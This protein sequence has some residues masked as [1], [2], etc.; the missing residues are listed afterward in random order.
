MLRHWSKHK[1]SR[2][3]SLVEFMMILPLIL[4]L[5]MV[6]IEV[7]R[8][9]HAWVGVENAARTGIRYAVT[10][11]WS[12][13]DCIILYGGECSSETQEETARVHSIKN[14]AISGSAAIILDEA[15]T[16]Y[17]PGFFG[18]TVCSK[19]GHL[20]MPTA[21]FESYTCNDDAGVPFEYAG[22]PGEYVIVGVDYNL[23]LISPI[24]STWFP[25][26]HLR[27]QRL[28]KVENYRFS[29][30]PAPPPDVP[31]NTATATKTPV[32]TDTPTIT[33]TP[34]RTA[35][36][37]KTPTPTATPDCSLISV[38][39]SK[40]NADKIQIQV[41]NRGS[42]NFELTNSSMDWTKSLGGQ[43][44]NFFKWASSNYYIGD[45]FSPP[46]ISDPAPPADFF[47]GTSINWVADFN[48]IS[49]LALY[50]GSYTV[51]L[52]FEY[53]CPITVHIA[54]VIATPTVPAP[55]CSEIYA[56]SVRVNG[57]DFEINVRNNNYIGA[58]LVGSNVTWPDNLTPNIFINDLA[59][60][61]NK[62][63]Y[64]DYH[65]SVTT[66]L[67]SNIELTSRSEGW[68]E[69]DFNNIPAAG[70]SGFFQGVLRFN[71]P[72]HGLT[73]TVTADL[74][75]VHTPVPTITTT[76]TPSRTP[77]IT[78]TP[79]PSR[80]P[81]VTRTP[82]PSI[83][84]TNTIT[85]TP[86]RTPTVTRTPSITPTPTST[87][88]PDCNKL[89]VSNV[90]FD[91][92]D[93]QF[94]IS[95]QNAMNIYLTNSVLTWPASQAYP[96]QFFNFF[97]FNTNLYYNTDS[98]S[99][100]V[101]AAAPSL[102]LG[103][104]WKRLWEADFD[105]VAGFLGTYGATLTFRFESGL[106]CSVSASRTMLPTSTPTPTNTSPPPTATN[107]PTITPICS[108][109]PTNTPIPPPSD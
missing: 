100:P 66:A 39:W 29:R 97:R 92:D 22:A 85:P 87:L 8:I 104:G 60:V 16:K 105:N 45:D 37:S 62:W 44:V 89:E 31:T 3:Q 19:P 68:W 93:F 26:L 84:P 73:C 96:P 54:N 51:E 65:T 69:V 82:T 12:E 27:S 1:K 11:E 102:Q 59:F 24:V 57:D 94:D 47:P 2:G 18:V 36:P 9:F 76:P 99:S 42:D 86:S 98:T 61:G 17:N 7:A 91:S 28:A 81:T 101:S 52:V 23:P 48:G 106:T 58:Y 4:T 80:T 15:A 79:T 64:G 10:G 75:V 50:D 103:P 107:T 53:S 14:A 55:D 20:Q 33:L 38:N 34:T 5:M 6:L 95:N 83:T 88:P 70:L 32:S 40:I 78:I 108:N 74:I 46:T 72:S 63:D 43:Y 13:E 90:G 25:I 71:Y 67:P 49:D 109:T 56:S 35:T 21:P 41:K 77:T 30:A